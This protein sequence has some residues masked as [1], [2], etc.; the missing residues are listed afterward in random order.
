MRTE[1]EQLRFLVDTIKAKDEIIRMQ[2][3]ALT[4][5]EEQLQILLIEQKKTKEIINK[6][7]NKINGTL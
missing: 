5:L 1:I 3:E 4:V 7:E 2:Q 6:I